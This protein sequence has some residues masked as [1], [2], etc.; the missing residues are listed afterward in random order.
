MVGKCSQKVKTAVAEDLNIDSVEERRNVSKEILDETLN[1]LHG[2][3][4]SDNPSM[5]QFRCDYNVT[6]DSAGKKNAE[7]VAG[8]LASVYPA[9]FKFDA[10]ALEKVPAKAGYGL[11]GIK[12]LKNLPSTICQRVIFYSKL[13]LA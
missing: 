11:G 6:L 12:G 3:F 9:M 10:T 13:S 5:S 8:L 2:V 4:G 1:A 7:R